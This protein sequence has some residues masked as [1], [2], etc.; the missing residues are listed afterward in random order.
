MDNTSSFR[1]ILNILACPKCRGPLELL[2]K[3]PCPGLNCAACAVV[4]P[5]REG[6]PVLLAEEALTKEAWQSGKCGAG[7]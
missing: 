1:D 4:Y 5:V 7:E 3:E 6:I 2:E